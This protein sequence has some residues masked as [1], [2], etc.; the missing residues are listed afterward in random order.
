MIFKDVAEVE[1]YFP[2]LAPRKRRTQ[3]QL[4]SRCP[5]CNAKA[6]KNVTIQNGGRIQCGRCGWVWRGK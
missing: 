4:P 6:R 3:V 5:H 1:A 2:T